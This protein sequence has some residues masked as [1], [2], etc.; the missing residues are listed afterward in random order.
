MEYR[1][2]MFQVI[3]ADCALFE[4]QKAFIAHVKTSSDLPTPSDIYK[5]IEHDRKFRFIKEPDVETLKRYKAKGIP[6]SAMQQ[7]ILDHHE[8]KPSTSCS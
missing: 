2:G 8:N 1:D 7:S 6:I 4:I 3:L 5:L